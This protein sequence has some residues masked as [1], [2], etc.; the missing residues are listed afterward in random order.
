MKTKSR[1]AKYKTKRYVAKLSEQKPLVEKFV[2]K[3]LTRGEGVFMRD[4]YRAW[5]RSMIDSGFGA[6]LSLNSFARLMPY[7]KYPR[8][9]TTRG[10]YQGSFLIGKALKNV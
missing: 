6:L 7:K 9:L 2:A 1:W 5:A 10:K 3:N 4:L 8:V